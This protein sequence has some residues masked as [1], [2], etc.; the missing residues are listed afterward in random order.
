ML[1]E[2]RTGRIRAVLDVFDQ[3]PLPADDQ[4]RDLDNVFLTP[5]VSGHTTE[6]RA[7][8]V[9]AIAADMERFFAGQPLRLAV[10]WERLKIMA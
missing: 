7:R 4:L 10:A 3:E 6:S 1:K 8:L 9:E 5:H 2:L